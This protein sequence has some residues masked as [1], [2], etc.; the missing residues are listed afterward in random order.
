LHGNEAVYTAYTSKSNLILQLEFKIGVFDVFAVFFLVIPTLSDTSEYTADTARMYATKPMQT[1]KTSNTS[2]FKF[3]V[4][5]KIRLTVNTY[6]S[7]AVI[8]SFQV[9]NQR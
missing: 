7:R 9:K 3:T 1:S 6:D 5:I 4:E 8:F 2:L